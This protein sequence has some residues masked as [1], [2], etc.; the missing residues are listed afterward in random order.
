MLRRAFIQRAQEAKKKEDAAQAQQQKASSQGQEK[1]ESAGD[2]KEMSAREATMLL[3]GYR[4][5]EAG[6]GMLHDKEQGKLEEVA[7]DW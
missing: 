4:Q 3:E 5:E 2:L 7:K 1:K 6:Q